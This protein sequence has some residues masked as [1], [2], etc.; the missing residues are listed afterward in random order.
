MVPATPSSVELAASTRS[1]LG[2][3]A[4]VGS[5]VA[6]VMRTTLTGRCCCRRCSFASRS[7]RTGLHRSSWRTA[8]PPLSS[9]M[10][11]RCSYRLPS[12][13]TTLQRKSK[14]LRAE[15]TA[16]HVAQT[17]EVKASQPD[18]RAKRQRAEQRAPAPFASPAAN[19]PQLE[20]APAAP[21]AAEEPQPEPQPDGAEHL[22]EAELDVQAAMDHAASPAPA[23]EA[24]PQAAVP[25]AAP[26]PDRVPAPRPATTPATAPAAPAIA[27]ATAPAPASA[28]DPLAGFEW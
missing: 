20:P 26:E 12:R 18:A 16:T 4:H 3:P 27:P 25:A 19:E 7:C 13:W 2:W 14:R 9:Q 24:V 6:A 28:L 10:R 1:A 15:L 22:D 21:P 11:R 23:Q 17:A 8:L 5:G